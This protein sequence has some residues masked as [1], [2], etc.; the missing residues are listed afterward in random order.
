[1]STDLKDITRGAGPGS[2]GALLRQHRAAAGLTATELAAMADCHQTYIG[3]LEREVKTPSRETVLALAEA[4][5]MT[6]SQ[7]DRLLFAAGR[8]T[9]TDYQQLWEAKHGSLDAPKWCP[10]CNRDL[11]GGAFARCLSRH[12]G[13][14]YICRQCDAVRCRAYRRQVKARRAS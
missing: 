13:R 4:L 5:D 8:A 1:M 11:P 7:T 14:Y 9:R 6:V 12:D 3:L 2:F 10:R